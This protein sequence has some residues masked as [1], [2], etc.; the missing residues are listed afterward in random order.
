MRVDKEVADRG[1]AQQLVDARDVAAFAEPHAARAPTEMLLV[2]VGGGV[3]LSAHR[4]PVAV[5]QR[6]EGVG[7]RG[8]DDLEIP[9]VLQLAQRLH[10]VSVMATPRVAHLAEAV[11]IHLG[12]LAIVRLVLGSPNFL[13]RERNQ[14][15]EVLGVARLQEV[16]RQHAEQR[17][18]HGHGAAE[19]DSIARQPLEHLDQREVCA[20]DGFIQPAFLHDRR[21]LRVPHERQVSVEDQTEIAS[22][23]RSDLSVKGRG[24][25][26]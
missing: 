25:S 20:S 16:V 15:I 12:E 4:R 5:H 9:G 23:H 11:P 21:V 6:E 3:N 1:F 7:R 10:E 8:R 2:Q 18:R 14:I 19:R 13:L 26:C 24:G 22:S 17:R